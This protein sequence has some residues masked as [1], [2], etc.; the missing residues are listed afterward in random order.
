MMMTSNLRRLFGATSFMSN[1]CWVHASA[2]GPPGAW[3]S[4]T[5]ITGAPF[6]RAVIDRHCVPGRAAVTWFA[7]F[8]RSRVGLLVLGAAHD[9]V[10]ALDAV[11]VVVGVDHAG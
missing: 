2:I 1:L 11:G 4:S 5:P 9:D 8:A 3:L 6:G 10:T 7:R